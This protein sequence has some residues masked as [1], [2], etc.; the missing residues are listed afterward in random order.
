MN[1]ENGTTVWVYVKQPTGAIVGKFTV[2]ASFSLTPRTLW[3][4]FSA[5]SGLTRTEF[6][7]YFEGLSKGFA[8]G[9]TSAEKLSSPISLGDLRKVAP[10]F[11]PPQFFKRLNP[12][13]VLLRSVQGSKVA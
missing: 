1:V 8:I 6:F 12:D 4:K 11:H 13:N 2:S 10:C 9:V 7:D 3:E 5:T